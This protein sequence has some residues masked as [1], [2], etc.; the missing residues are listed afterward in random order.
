MTKEKLINDF[1]KMEKIDFEDVM[2]VEEVV[3]PGW[4]THTCCNPA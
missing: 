3:T 1:I 2:E 4:G